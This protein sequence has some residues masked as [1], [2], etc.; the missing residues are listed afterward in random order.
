MF[1]SINMRSFMIFIFFFVSHRFMFACLGNQS[2]NQ[3]FILLGAKEEETNCRKTNFTTNTHTI[4]IKNKNKQN[5]QKYK[6][7]HRSH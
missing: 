5:K 2:I 4:T 6:F 7:Y 1:I 3:S